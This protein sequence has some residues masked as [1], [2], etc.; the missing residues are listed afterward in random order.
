[1]ITANY[2]NTGKN[3]R[4][5][6]FETDFIE[7]QA[8]SMNV[9]GYAFHSYAKPALNSEVPW[10]EYQSRHMHVFGV[11]N[12]NPKGIAIVV[13]GGGGDVGYAENVLSKAIFLSTQG[14]I[15]AS[16]EYRRGWSDAGFNEGRNLFTLNSDEYARQESSAR[17][18]FEDSKLALEFITKKYPEA[19]KK[20]IILEGTSFG[21]AIVLALTVMN[22]EAE[23]Y[24]FIG[25]IA[26][27]GGIN[28]SDVVT[29]NNKL[30]SPKA[31]PLVLIGG[32]AD[33]IV[34][35][36]E[37]LYYCNGRI[38]GYGS[39]VIANL[40]REAGGHARLIGTVNK[41]HG[42]GVINESSKEQFQILEDTIL[43]LKR[44]EDINDD[45][46][47]KATPSGDRTNS[48]IDEALSGFNIRCNYAN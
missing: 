12:T 18:S 48:D 4:S 3:F 44:G 38:T 17:I 22:K 35:F 13:H 46:W 25:G 29:N 33:P 5:S 39:A 15:A 21:G 24:K 42:Y 26:G 28:A 47:Y 45:T 34:P 32:T 1:M 27:F 7:E 30:I 19:A 6:L 14:W 23:K 20:G 37:G 43:S 10:Q 11:N 36:W 40:I 31:C 9:N 41:G 2:Q 8:I 16:I